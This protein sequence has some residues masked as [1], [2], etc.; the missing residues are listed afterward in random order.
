MPGVLLA[1]RAVRD[2]PGLTVGLDALLGVCKPSR[3]ARVAL[4]HWGCEAA[5]VP[6]VGQRRVDGIDHFGP[7]RSAGD[8]SKW[9]DLSGNLPPAVYLLIP[10]ALGLALLTALV[11]GPLGEPA[12]SA[13][14]AG[15]VTRA[16]E[17]RPASEGE[18]S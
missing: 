17:R 11:L 10:L 1:V 5:L 16:L 4:V 2:R 7:R 9:G 8:P 15:G 6:V 14:R 3:V 13:R 18:S 12:A